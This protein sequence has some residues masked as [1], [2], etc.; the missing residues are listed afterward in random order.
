[1]AKIRDS[2][3]YKKN[4]KKTNITPIIIGAVIL[5]VL[6]FGAVLLFRDKG[7]DNPLSPDDIIDIDSTAVT[8]QETDL[9]SGQVEAKIR[10]N[11][12]NYAYYYNGEIVYSTTSG[13]TNYRKLK[14]Y[15]SETQS[16]TEIPVKCL[17]NNINNIV[18]NDRY[19]AFTD[20]STLGGGR[21]CAIDRSTG[22]QII[23][24]D[25]AYAM[26]KLKLIGN[27]LAFMQQAGSETDR[28]YLV[29]L[30][31]GEAIANKVFEGSAMVG[32]GV[33]AFDE[34]IIYSVLYNEGETFSS[35]VVVLNVIDGTETVYEF[36][37]YVYEPM[38][39]GNYIVFLSSASGVAD[40]IFLSEAGGAP[41]LLVSD[42]TNM[43][44]GDGFI[45]YTKDGGIHAYVLSSGKFYRLNTPVS[46][47]L[48][49]SVN[50]REVCWYDVTD[51][52]DVNSIKYMI[53][54][55]EK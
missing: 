30:T 20:S 31:T 16:S 17:Y 36:D 43:I 42:V 51:Y 14:I 53:L 2:Y 22:D 28:L 12:I 24:K 23:I 32:G 18:M 40:D 4:R 52:D 34:G 41:K 25:Y 7:E 48:L 35:R 10:D 5:V 11:A 21:I 26:P 39:C 50:G 54:D 47:G 19:I 3:I 6:I 1:M 27:V 8:D 33:F 29:D 9:S 46:S 13:G 55:W 15:T 44:A 37:R 49:S 38:I 45:A